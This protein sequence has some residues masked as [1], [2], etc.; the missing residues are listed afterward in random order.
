MTA[1]KW[2]ENN[3]ENLLNRAK[4]TGSMRKKYY[5][6][7][8]S[9]ILLNW[10]ENEDVK[11]IKVT[12][13]KGNV[14]EMDLYNS[15]PYLTYLQKTRKDV[16]IVEGKFFLMIRQSNRIGE[17]AN[18]VLRMIDMLGKSFSKFKLADASNWVDLDKMN[19]ILLN[20]EEVL[21][22]VDAYKVMDELTDF[23]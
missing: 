21:E 12:Y 5:Q 13:G 19:E 23:S 4:V 17:T 10:N 15:G 14:I 1:V 8:L 20:V 11:Y 22:D 16:T 6:T 3:R 7:E 2:F 9:D 18:K